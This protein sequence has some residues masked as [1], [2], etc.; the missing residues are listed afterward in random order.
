MKLNERKHM[1][2]LEVSLDYKDS[3]SSDDDIILTNFG[4]IGILIRSRA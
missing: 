4:R 1:N 2:H 3:V